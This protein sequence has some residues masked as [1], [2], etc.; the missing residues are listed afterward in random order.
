M[1]TGTGWPRPWRT[2]WA[3]RC[4]TAPH[5]STWL[6]RAT[7]VGG[8][9]IR[10]RDAGPGVAEA[11]RPRLFSRFVTGPTTGGTGLG[12][13]IVRELV[14]SQG[15]DATY[16]PGGPESPAGEFVIRLPGASVPPRDAAGG[17]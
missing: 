9:E 14:R 11:V 10:V 6:A 15:G 1:P 12:L 17:R 3:T 8:V 4:D 13:F 16:D 2:C 5:P 7:D